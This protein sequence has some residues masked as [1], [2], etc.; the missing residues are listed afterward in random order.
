M[1]WSRL[2]KAKESVAKNIVQYKSCQRLPH[3][4]GNF[5]ATIGP[6]MSNG[7]E[8]VLASVCRAANPNDSTWA[9]PCRLPSPRR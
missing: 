9:S 7:I 4:W 2:K 1:S 6:S 3:R 5:G 8:V